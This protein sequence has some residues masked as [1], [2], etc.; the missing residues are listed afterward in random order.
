MVPQVIHIENAGMIPLKEKCHLP[1]FLPTSRQ[2]SRTTC[3]LDLAC[4][5][6]SDLTCFR[7]Q[8]SII[9]FLPQGE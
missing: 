5:A 2:W 8:S 1:T 9:L 3:R 7:T 4:I 6:L